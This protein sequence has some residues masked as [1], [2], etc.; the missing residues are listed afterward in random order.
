MTESQLPAAPIARKQ[1]TETR[2]HGVALSDDYAWLRDKQNPEVTAYLEAE[3]A[4]A[5]A[6]W[7]R[8]PACATTSTGRCSATSSR[9]TSPS[10]SAMAT[11]GT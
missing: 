1:H 5:E 8:W 3:N 6:G 4:Y 11:G 9:P 7:L 2:L 10:P